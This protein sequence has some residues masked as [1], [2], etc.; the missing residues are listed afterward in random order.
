MDNRANSRLNKKLG[1]KSGE[2][3]VWGIKSWK[4]SDILLGIQKFRHMPGV[5][6]M[7]RKDMRRPLA[8][9]ENLSKQQ[10]MGIAK[11]E[12]HTAWLTLKTCPNTTQS[13][14]TKPGRCS[15][16]RKFSTLSSPVAD[17]LA[18]EVETLI[19]THNKE[20]TKALVQNGSSTKNKQLQKGNHNKPVGKR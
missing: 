4:S 10:G 7:L 18:K 17:H 12:W 14:S 9:P 1:G 19:V 2:G 8:D 13:P 11:A 5:V 6:C 20:Q 15:C 16:S 3:D